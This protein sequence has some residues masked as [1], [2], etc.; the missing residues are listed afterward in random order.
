V[1]RLRDLEAREDDLNARLSTA[2]VELPALH[3]NIADIYARKVARLA[4]ALNQPD[5]RLEAIRGLIEKIVL[6]PGA[7]RGELTATL[8]GELGIILEW[9]GQKGLGL[10]RKGIAQKRN[11]PGAGLS[12]VS[13]SVVAGAGFEPTTFRL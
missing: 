2:P 12:R 13:A 7:K 11:T 10:A 9:T 6:T 4:E 1:A 5:E 8:H 3:P